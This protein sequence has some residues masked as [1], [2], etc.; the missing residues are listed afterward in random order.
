MGK[1]SKERIVPIGNKACNA[2]KKYLKERDCTLKK[3]NISSKYLFLKENGHKITRQDV[4]KFINDIG[5]T[6]NKSISPHTIRHSFATH[7]L[8]NGADLRVVQELLGH[9]SISTT[10]IYTHVDNSQIRDAVANNPLAN[11]HPDNK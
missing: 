6:I 11:Y 10:E 3:N 9:E 1:G 2:I 5:K 7:L 8:E 4:Y